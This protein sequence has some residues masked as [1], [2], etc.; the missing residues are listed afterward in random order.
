MGVMFQAESPS[1]DIPQIYVNPLGTVCDQ[2][3]T[4]AGDGYWS[5]EP[6]WNGE[7]EVTAIRGADSWS[8]EMRIPL[9]QFA[10]KADS[11]DRWRVQ[12]RRKQARTSSTAALQA[13]WQYDPTGFG[14]LVME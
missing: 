2:L 10:A 9:A 11:G 7:V 14:E 12:F 13:P 6:A 3:I 5:G 8:V 1:G 4:Q